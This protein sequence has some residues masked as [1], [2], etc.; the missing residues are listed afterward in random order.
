MEWTKKKRKPTYIVLNTNLT[1]LFVL[2]IA[3]GHLYSLV[4]YCKKMNKR[5]L[6]HVHFEGRNI[7]VF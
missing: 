1:R 2:I 5:I 6:A 4:E 7:A 3:L